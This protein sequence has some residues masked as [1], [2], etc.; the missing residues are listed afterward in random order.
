[1]SEITSQV[2]LEPDLDSDVVRAWDDLAV[3]RGR[4]Y[5]APGWMLSWNIA[6]RGR[7]HVWIGV[8]REASEIIGVIPLSGHPLPMGRRA[9]YELLGSGTSFRIEPL[10]MP[11]RQ[12][13]VAEAAGELLAS[14]SPPLGLLS[15]RGIDPESGWTQA[16]AAAYPGPRRARVI[17]R[18]R[19]HAPTM[20]VNGVADYESW[21]R[22]KSRNFRQ[23]AAHGRRR[24]LDI[25]ELRI[26]STASELT[27]AMEAFATLH[28]GRWGRRSG[29]ARDY[30]SLS[31]RLIAAGEQLGPTRIRASTALVDDEIIAVQIF[32]LAGDVAAYWNG[33][34][35]ESFRS[36]RPGWTTLLAAIEDAI[37]LGIDEIDLGP[38][39]HP[40]KSRLATA[41]GTVV[42]DRVIPRSPRRLAPYL[43]VGA[44]Q[45]REAARSRTRVRSRP[46]SVDSESRA[47]PAHG[48]PAG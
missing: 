32:L 43:Y 8:V 22:A 30:S 2:V 47:G 29:L 28:R 31:A 46:P 7:S 36:F 16:L 41:A 18:N 26:A 27:R 4:P 14:L 20:S 12:R 11:G 3:A 1:M 35:R 38:G 13:A 24:F 19:L 5:C 37:N 48:R 44:G 25:G 21:L 42:W 6:A 39:A 9:R 34:W 33:G 15:L 40:Y 17:R 45:L 10:A 23:Q